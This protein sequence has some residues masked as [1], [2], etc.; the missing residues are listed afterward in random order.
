MEAPPVPEP[1]RVEVIKYVEK[2]SEEYPKALERIQQ[3][4]DSIRNQEESSAKALSDKTA[5]LGDAHAAYEALKAETDANQAALK[6]QLS[7]L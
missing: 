5:E 2:E 1:E 3:L 7:S 6:D 4:E